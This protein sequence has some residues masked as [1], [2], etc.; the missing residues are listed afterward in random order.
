VARKICVTE[1]SKSTGPLFWAE[2][3]VDKWHKEA[4]V[5]LQT[6]ENILA[7]K[8]SFLGNINCTYSERC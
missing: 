2:R 8:P 7:V 5:F 3:S 6:N 4:A 1:A